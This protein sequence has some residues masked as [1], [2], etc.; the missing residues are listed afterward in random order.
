MNI[1]ARD[2]KE[3]RRG[4]KKEAG[5]QGNRESDATRREHTVL[6]TATVWKRIL[7]FYTNTFSEI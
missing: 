6:Y 4:L 3:G 5:L 1:E 7:L 2:K